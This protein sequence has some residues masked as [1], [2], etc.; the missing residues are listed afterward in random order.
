[1]SNRDVERTYQNLADVLEFCFQREIRNV[2]TTMPGKIVSYENGLAAIEPGLRVLMTD[3]SVR[4]RPVL[5]NVP[6]LHPAGGGYR[7]HVPLRAGDPVILLFAMRGIEEWKRTR[8]CVQPRGWGDGVGRSY[9]HPGGF[10]R[11]DG[12]GWVGDRRE[13]RLYPARRV[14]DHAIRECECGWGVDRGRRS[15]VSR[16]VTPTDKSK[17]KRRIRQPVAFSGGKILTVL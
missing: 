2:H 8:G 1:M 10:C 6:V 11:W 7:V 13:R 5:S 14:G 17:L 16:G 12:A 15:G 4:D 3:G 9:G